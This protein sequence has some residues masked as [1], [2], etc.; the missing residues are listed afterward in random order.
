MQVYV[1]GAYFIFTLFVAGL[2]LVPDSFVSTTTL[3]RKW[4]M[5]LHM[6]GQVL[7]ALLFIS[8]TEKEDAVMCSVIWKDACA[9][10][11]LAF[12]FIFPSFYPLLAAA[13]LSYALPLQIIASGIH[14]FHNE[15]MCAAGYN[16]CENAAEHY[17]WVRNLLTEAAAAIPM[18]FGG[19]EV[20]VETN[21]YADCM[22]VLS[23]IEIFML[24]ICGIYAT[25][26]SEISSRIAYCHATNRNA[27][28][29]EL[30]HRKVP[31]WQ[32]LG[33]V[34]VAAYVVWNIIELILFGV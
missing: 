19:Q 15:T 25:F 6:I 9:L 18:K 16:V 28:Q 5:P 17:K 3:R 34:L 31:F 4:R 23:F 27:M 22:A 2:Y 14:I 7:F 30:W 24:V 8:V 21:K 29:L 20:H 11:I 1:L 33:E 13:L 12:Y 32:L 10:E 26:A